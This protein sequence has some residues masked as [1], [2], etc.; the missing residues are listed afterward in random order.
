MSADVSVVSGLIIA[1]AFGR[2]IRRWYRAGTSGFGTGM[3]VNIPLLLRMPAARMILWTLGILMAW[4]SLIVLVVKYD[5]WWLALAAY[6]VSRTLEVPLLKLLF[7]GD[8]EAGLALRR[9]FGPEYDQAIRTVR[10]RDPMDA[11][12]KW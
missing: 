3:D 2:F 5:K 6:L 8:V 11:V 4:G 7:R 12:L 1:C 10:G 9:E